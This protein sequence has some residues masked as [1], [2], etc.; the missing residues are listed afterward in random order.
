[1]KS[2]RLKPLEV[3]DNY[4]R[5]QIFNYIFRN[6]GVGYNEVKKALG[7]AN[8]T[9]RHHLDIL[10]QTGYMSSI[11][12]GNGTLYYVLD[13]QTDLLT[14]RKAHMDRTLENTIINCEG[15]I[16]NSKRKIKA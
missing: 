8:A 6:S 1:M 3:L 13:K 10:I 4:T 2:T 14:Q 5:A 7:V 16:K 9:V 15:A 11:S 12:R